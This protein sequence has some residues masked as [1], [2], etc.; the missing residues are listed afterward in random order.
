MGQYTYRL[1][2]DEATTLRHGFSWSG[3]YIERMIQFVMSILF[4]FGIVRLAYRILT[5]PFRVLFAGRSV[6]AFIKHLS[7]SGHE[8]PTRDQACR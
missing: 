4:L 3:F 2:V 7:C 1:T 5:L 8:D 6:P